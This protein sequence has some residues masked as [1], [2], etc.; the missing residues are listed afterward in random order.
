MKTVTR[1]DLANVVRDAAITGVVRASE[2]SDFVDA[3]LE[4]IS[5][6]IVRGETVKISGFGS[7]EVRYKRA[8]PGRNPKR[9]QELHEIP[10]HRSVSFRASREL[11]GHVK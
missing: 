4:E 10:A 6:A 2:A 11:K 7:F 5:A 8:R 9:P 3:M 1:I